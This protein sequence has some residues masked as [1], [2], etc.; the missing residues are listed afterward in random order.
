MNNISEPYIKDQAQVELLEAEMRGQLKY[1]LMNDFLA[2][3]SL[4]K[5]LYALAGLL[6][7]LLEIDVDDITDIEV[8]NP[9]E[10]SEVITSKD[11]VLD[12]KLELNH[13]DIINL[14][15]QNQ[16][17]DFWPERSLTYLSRIFDQLE[18]G[19]EYSEIKQCI[20]IGILKSAPFREDDGRNT[21]LFL[22]E[23]SLR[24]RNTGKEY[25]SKFR[26]RVLSLKYMENATEK[27]K[28]SPNGV[29]YWAKLLTAKSWEELRMVAEDNTRMKSFVG[30]VR[31]LTADEKVKEACERRR[32]YSNEIATYEGEIGRL[33]RERDRL[34]DTNTALEEKRN[35]L[36]EEKNSLEEE[37]NSLEEANTSLEKAKSS[38]ETKNRELEDE[39]KRLKALLEE[40]NN[41]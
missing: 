11:C 22:S 29:Y 16:F 27:E 36:E 12:I 2:K 35:S 10:P 34:I 1:T 3:Y 4:Q 13:K 31:Q 39:V 30:T 25:S 9:I 38:L 6:A 37:K 24:E 15:I 26:I 40:K 19:D 17:Q 8:L 21:G 33:S 18:E 14:E 5:D 7:A 41:A 20:Q 32:R 28:V 23:Y